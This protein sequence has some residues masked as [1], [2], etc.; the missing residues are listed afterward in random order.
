MTWVE[1]VKDHFAVEQQALEACVHAWAQ[2]PDVR[3]WAQ[4]LI[5]ADPFLRGFG[6]AEAR[7]RFTCGLVLSYF[8]GDW[9]NKPAV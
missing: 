3:A 2:D 5:A 4:L 7:W 8:V 1:L 9:P 6:E